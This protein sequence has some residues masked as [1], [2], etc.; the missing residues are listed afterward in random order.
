MPACL[1]IQTVNRDGATVN[2]TANL[3]AAC[4]SGGNYWLNTGGEFL[5]V[6]NLNG[7]NVTLTQVIHETV[8]GQS[9]TNKTVVLTNGTHVALLG[10]YPTAPY[11]NNDNFANV[12]YSNATGIS[13][14]ALQL[15][16]VT[17]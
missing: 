15:T 14:A 6:Q 8:D 7:A 2:L 11:N 13:I 16:T 10:P 4:T 12:L 1:T 9:V 3:V 17:N 5:A